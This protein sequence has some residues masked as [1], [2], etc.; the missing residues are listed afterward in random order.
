MPP[1][2][3]HSFHHGDLRQTALAAARERVSRAGVDKLSLRELATELGVNHRALYRHFPDKQQLIL[4]LAAGE[5]HAMVDAI[6]DAVAGA[7]REDQSRALI[8]AY[9]HYAFENP[10]LYEMVFSL[11]LRDE[12]DDDTS[13]GLEVK[14][15]IDACAKAFARPDDTDARIRNRVLQAW[16]AAH[17]L[18]LLIFRGALRVGARAQTERYI[19]GTSLGL[20]K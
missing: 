14:R 5:V 1:A 19:V 4:E 10:R 18:I 13:V 8:Q 7:P 9:V 15:L 17:G 12:F 16:G 3:R 6:G 2:E 20:N 11:P